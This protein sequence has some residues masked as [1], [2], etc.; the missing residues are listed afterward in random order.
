LTPP[1]PPQPDAAD[2]GE[3]DEDEKDDEEEK[4]PEDQEEQ[5]ESVPD[6]PQE[7]MFSAAGMPVDPE[8]LKFANKARS[9]QSGGRG[10]LF[11]EDR[12]RYI[13][14]MLPRG[15]VKRLAVDA[16]LRA[17]APYQKARRE[18]NR[19]NPN[20]KTPNKNVFIEMADVRVK[21]M[22]RPAGCLV[23]FL[24]DASGSMALNRMDAAKG[25]AISL[26]ESAYQNRDKV[27]VIPFQ[28]DRAEV[29]LPPTKSTAMAKSRLES[30]P[31]GGGSPLAHA[32]NTAVR[33]GLNAMSSGDVGQV[34]VVLLTDGRANVPLSKAHNGDDPALA[35]APAAPAA[36]G[37]AKAEAPK[38]MTMEEIKTEV[39]DAA[40]Q[41]R[42]IPEFNVVVLDTEEKFISTGM[43]KEI[44]AACG[45]T[46]KYL[47]KLSSQALAVATNDVVESVRKN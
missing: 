2:E 9:G 38:K 40:K 44:A 7:F 5:E 14:P 39:L 22:A 30:M 34:I 24:V 6:V 43:T 32:I 17:A 37:D 41:L 28:G 47:P 33:T 31:C 42:A 20:S 29:L 46:Y 1:P 4:D 35:P 45:A 13:K 11:S 26:L 25:A 15:K 27:C 23:I 36:K 18:R 12:G 8:I 21:K 19:A 10:M 3:K 16:T